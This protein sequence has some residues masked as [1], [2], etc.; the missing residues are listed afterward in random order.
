[1][2]SKKNK[3]HISLQLNPQFLGFKQ[4]NNIKTPNTK[5]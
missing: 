5:Q 1:M 3:N 4:D 2:D